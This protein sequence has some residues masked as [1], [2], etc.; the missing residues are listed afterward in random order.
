VLT[1]FFPYLQ[2]RGEITGRVV[3]TETIELALAQ[4][5]KSV[6]ILRKKVDYYCRLNNSPDLDDIKIVTEGVEWKGFQQ[7]WMQTC[8]WIP[9][10]KNS[11]YKMRGN[12]GDR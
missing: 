8:A 3:P 7:N 1:V 10:A 4:V 9:K 12:I 6:E 2:A 11:T 5:P